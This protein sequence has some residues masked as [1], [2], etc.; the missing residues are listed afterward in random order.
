M[1]QYWNIIADEYQ[2]V[3][4]ISVDDF[5]YGPL[6]PGDRALGL[7][8]PLDPGARCLELACGAGQNSLYLASA[9]GADCV[10]ID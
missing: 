7:I 4:H 6:L 1:P 10:A 3:T 9:Y 2:D 8:P 5:H